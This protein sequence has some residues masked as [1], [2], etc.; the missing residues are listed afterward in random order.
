M[1]ELY[2]LEKD[3]WEIENLIE[4]RGYKEI[5]IQLKKMLMRHM[6]DEKDPLRFCGHFMLPGA[7]NV[8]RKELV[9]TDHFNFI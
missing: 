9:S 3:P 2:D 5:L 7:E 6:M 4:D 1:D 8:E